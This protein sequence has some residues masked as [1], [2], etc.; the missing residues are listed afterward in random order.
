MNVYR[1]EH[2]DTF[3][4]FNYFI[5][6]GVIHEAEKILYKIDEGGLDLDLSYVKNDD[7][8]LLGRDWLT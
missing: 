6:V 5:I 1:W 7:E 3:S 4:E 8:K 2:Q